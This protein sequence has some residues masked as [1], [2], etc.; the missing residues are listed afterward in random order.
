MSDYYHFHDRI[1]THF[2]GLGFFL[3]SLCCTMDK[4]QQPILQNI[5][6]FL[7]FRNLLVTSRLI[8]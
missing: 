4:L 1:K 6:Q 5:A 7:S 3:S 8:S 2:S